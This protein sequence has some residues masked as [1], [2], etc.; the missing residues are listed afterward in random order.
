MTDTNPLDPTIQNERQRA[1]DQAYA[2]VPAPE[3]EEEEAVSDET[4]TI[5][6]AAFDDMCEWIAGGGDLDWWHKNGADEDD[7]TWELAQRV[8]RH[9][10]LGYTVAPAPEEVAPEATLTEEAAADG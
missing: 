7:E 5:P 3:G 10:R 6:R 2:M 8:N 9:L 4:I 1:L